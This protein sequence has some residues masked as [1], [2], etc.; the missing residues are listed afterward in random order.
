MSMFD[1]ES[2]GFNCPKCGQKHE[3]TVGWLKANN[4]IVCPCG[5]NINLDVRDLIAGTDKAEQLIRDF[6]RRIMINL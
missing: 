5:I 1:S 2:V 6:P 4:K 3:K